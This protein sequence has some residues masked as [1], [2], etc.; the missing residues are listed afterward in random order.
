MDI[1]MDMDILNNYIMEKGNCNS[2]FKYYIMYGIFLYMIKILISEL[3]FEIRKSENKRENKINF[4]CYINNL[5]ILQFIYKPINKNIIIDCLTNPKIKKEIQILI[6]DKKVI[7][8]E[9]LISFYKNVDTFDVYNEYC[10]HLV[11]YGKT[12]FNINESNINYLNLTFKGNDIKTNHA[13]LNFYKW[14]IES[15]LYMYIKKNN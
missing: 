8:Y 12:N 2:N 3:L 6:E 1:D 5:K 10:L 14:V 7:A 15:G 13:E 11:Y 4:Y 9:N